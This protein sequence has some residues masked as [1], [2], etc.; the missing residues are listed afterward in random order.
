MRDV[1]GLYPKC[2][3]FYHVY[4]VITYNTPHINIT[5]VNFG[6]YHIAYYETFKSVCLNTP[7]YQDT[8]IKYV[9]L[10]QLQID[11]NIMYQFLLKLN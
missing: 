9:V 1:V 3:A 11:A 2:S 6:I 7:I 8:N 5:L 4:R 10:S